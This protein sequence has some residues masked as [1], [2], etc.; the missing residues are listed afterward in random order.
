[1]TSEKRQQSQVIRKDVLSLQIA[2]YQYY[3]P[4]VTNIYTEI[5]IIEAR[6][7]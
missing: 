6:F 1:M 7:P 3:S 5:L 4:K 2:R